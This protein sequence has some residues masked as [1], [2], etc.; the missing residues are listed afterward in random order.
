MEESI[1][2][3]MHCKV[4]PDRARD[5]EL[6][7]PTFCSTDFAFCKRFWQRTQHERRHNSAPNMGPGG[8]GS[9]VK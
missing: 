5:Q 6:G 9:V 2:V 8:S 1:R 7:K 4:L 3:P